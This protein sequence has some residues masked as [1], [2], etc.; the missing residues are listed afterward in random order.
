MT[1]KFKER[2]V[3]QKT[4]DWRVVNVIDTAEKR[5]TV[6]DYSN[7]PELYEVLVAIEPQ[8]VWD[9]SNK[10]KVRGWENVYC[11]IYG[12]HSWNET[13]EKEIHWGKAPLK[14]GDVIKGHKVLAVL[15]VEEKE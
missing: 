6:H 14:P 5:A 7:P 8:P 10:G 1:D 12:R 9:E 11:K 2:R 4:W 15:E 13:I 3:E